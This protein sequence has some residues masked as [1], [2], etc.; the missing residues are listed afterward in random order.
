[1]SSVDQYITVAAQQ[2]GS[3][4][5]RRT[6]ISGLSA[7]LREHEGVLWGLIVAEK[8]NLFA[9]QKIIY[10]DFSPISRSINV[11]DISLMNTKDGLPA[12]SSFALQPILF[13]HPRT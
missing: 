4:F 12:M 1:M 8:P 13:R 2:K 6:I 7:V 10:L 11:V 9:S 5:G 3:W